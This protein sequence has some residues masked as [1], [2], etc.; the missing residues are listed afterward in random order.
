MEDV[1]VKN[2]KIADKRRE[3]GKGIGEEEEVRG[4][5]REIKGMSRIMQRGQRGRSRKS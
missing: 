4:L 3:E 1:L 5:R 2:A